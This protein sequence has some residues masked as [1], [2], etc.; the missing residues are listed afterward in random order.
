MSN[1]SSPR[2]TLGDC[3]FDDADNLW[4]TTTDKNT[5]LDLYKFKVRCNDPDG[6]STLRRYVGDEIIR[7][8]KFSADLDLSIDPNSYQSAEEQQ[9][10]KYLEQTG[11]APKFNPVTGRIIIPTDPINCAVAESC[12]VVYLSSIDQPKVSGC[13]V[14]EN[15]TDREGS[16]SIRVESTPAG[17]IFAVCDYVDLYP[18][19]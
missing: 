17:F 6:M 1:F 19:E 13:S 14:A 5:G 10:K 11:I 18:N 7:L 8:R 3:V 9:Y 4:H 12:D 2:F 16:I 15:L